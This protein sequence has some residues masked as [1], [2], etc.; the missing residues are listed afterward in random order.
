MIAEHN[1]PP[2]VYFKTLLLNIFSVKLCQRGDRFCCVN[3][4]TQFVNEDTKSGRTKI[5]LPPFFKNYDARNLAQSMETLQYNNYFFQE[6]RAFVKQKK[7]F[8]SNS[9]RLAG[10]FLLSPALKPDNATCHVFWL[11][12]WLLT[13][14]TCDVFSL[15]TGH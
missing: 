5:E 1:I 10:V 14:S 8:C 11:C 13:C 15:N 4:I 6:D 7:L 2:V 12:L 9:S 3:K